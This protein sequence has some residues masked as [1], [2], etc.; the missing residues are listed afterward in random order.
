[1]VVMPITR[2]PAMPFA[3]N[4]AE[5]ATAL[6]LTVSPAEWA[7]DAANEH[8]WAV[9]ER[10]LQRHIKAGAGQ[11]W[12]RSATGLCV[13]F[14]QRQTAL[15]CAW[16]M[17]L[18]AG[19]RPAGRWRLSLDVVRAAGAVDV[20]Q[21]ARLHGLALL[22]PDSVPVM[23]HRLRDQLHDPVEAQVEDLGM[24][25]LKHLEPALRAYRMHQPP[26]CVASMALPK[27]A[28]PGLP[29]LV[30]LAPVAIA[31][32][33]AHRSFGALLADRL[34]HQL[35]RSAHLRLVHT[36]SSQALA[37]RAQTQAQAHEEARHWLAADY[38]LK[39]TYRVLGERGLG[40]LQLRLSLHELLGDSVVWAQE[41]RA[42]VGDVL[43]ADSELVQAVSTGVHHAVLYAHMDWARQQ[44]VRSLDDYALLLTGVG[45]MHRSA[46]DDL[47]VSR[48]A[49]LA[50]L[51]RAPEMG[52]AHAW[53][54]K[55][56][57]LR[58]TRA[59]SPQPDQ[60][61]DQAQAHAQ[62]A[63]VASDAQGLAR[64][65]QGFVRLHLLRDLP[66]ALSELQLCTQL[67][68]NEP[69]AWLFLGVAES[70]ADHGQHAMQ[71]SQRAMALSPLDPLLYYFESL[72]AS[73]AIVSGDAAQAR[74][75]C[76]QSLRRNVM[77]LSTHR[78][79]ITALSMEGQ[80]DAARQ[81]A[82]Q[83]L[84][85]APGYTVA[86]FAR[87]GSSARTRLGQCVHRALLDAGVPAGG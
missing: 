6:Y 64:A 23:G 67:H 55:W 51:E 38:V 7:E 58:V 22:A 83:M 69:L 30:L 74:R 50:L 8:T 71:A 76:E 61:A 29:R 10:H 45:L 5:D 86:Q 65:M 66:G 87:S 2:A 77:H 15:D 13:A 14:S 36:L 53:L 49:L 34:S 35:G 59:L 82:L 28:A 57:V 52:Q 81:A 21:V 39:G 16:R 9:A 17:P 33:P 40:T 26:S 68:P 41:F 44:P 56:H 3:S 25:H 12:H 80:I 11:W 48:Q 85:L 42:E 19:L 18:L 63:M 72:A 47:D 20:S 73:S 70:F 79:Y 1:M 24:C 78:A 60:E 27:T 37:R 32:S 54:A 75:W 4:P 46:P 31:D 84:R 62:R 43:A